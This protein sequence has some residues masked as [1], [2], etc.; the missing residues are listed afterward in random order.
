MNKPQSLRNALNKAVPYVRNNPDKL[1]L[2]V[3]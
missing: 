1:H 2:F 3:D